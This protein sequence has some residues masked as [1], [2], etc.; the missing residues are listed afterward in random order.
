M[1]EIIHYNKTNRLHKKSRDNSSGLKLSICYFPE[2]HLGNKT[3]RVGKQEMEKVF[4]VS[5]KY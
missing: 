5:G 4:G 2:K 1:A 3:R